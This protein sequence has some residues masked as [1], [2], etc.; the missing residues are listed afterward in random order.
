[1]PQRFQLTYKDKD[2]KEKTPVMLHRTIYGSLE[3][4]IGILLEHYSGKLP[5]WLAPIQVRLI[6]F[7][8]KNKKAVKK[9]EKMMEEK[10]IRVDID[11][12]DETV[13]SKIK[14]AELMKIPYIIVIG[15]KEEKN[16][17]LAVRKE[18]K[19]KSIKQ[20]KF[21]KDLIKEINKRKYN[22]A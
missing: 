13:S 12:N 11:I 17:S 10:R 22:E 20:D 18:G 9:I 16:N 4:F 19:V 2:N 7:T 1:M 8:E 5:V 15:D 6:S 14:K 3:R 21:I